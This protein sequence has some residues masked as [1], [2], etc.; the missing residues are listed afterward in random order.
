LQKLS[1]ILLKARAVP[2]RNK[3]VHVLLIAHAAHAVETT[4]T[5]IAINFKDLYMRYK[6][7]K[8]RKGEKIAVK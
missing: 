6:K 2:V 8:R 7:S 5:A 4:E 1:S 3:T